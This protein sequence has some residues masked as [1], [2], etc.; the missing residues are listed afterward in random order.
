MRTGTNKQRILAALDSLADDA[1]IEE[2]IELLYFLDQV[3]K[4]GAN[5]DT[6]PVPEDQERTRRFLRG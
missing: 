1:T 6:P 2:A 5:L 3:Q 4:S